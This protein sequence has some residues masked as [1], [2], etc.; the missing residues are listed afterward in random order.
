MTSV[1][2]FGLK[3]KMCQAKLSLAELSQLNLPKTSPKC[4]YKR[5]GTL[6]IDKRGR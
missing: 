2:S 4:Q 6:I 3:F 1:V 5:K